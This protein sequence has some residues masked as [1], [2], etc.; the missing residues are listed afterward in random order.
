M[1]ALVQERSRR[2][3]EKSKS[4][5]SKPDDSDKPRATKVSTSTNPNDISS[6]VESVKRKSGHARLEEGHRS[7]KRARV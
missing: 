4:R 3:K 2:Q 5:S 7:S 1:T 6:L